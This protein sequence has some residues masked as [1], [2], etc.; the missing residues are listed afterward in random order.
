MT[1]QTINVRSIVFE[2]LSKQLDFNI[3]QMQ[4]DLNLQH[5]LGA[6]SLDTFEIQLEIERAFNIKLSDDTFDNE[7]SAFDNIN[8]VGQILELTYSALGLKI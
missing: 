2:I 5:D 8:T 1:D 4:E 3:G 7:T 6:D